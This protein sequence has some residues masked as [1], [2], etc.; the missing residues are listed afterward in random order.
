MTETTHRKGFIRRFFGAIGGAITWL[1]RVFTN[2]LFLLLLLFIFAAIFGKEERLTVPQGAA[3]KLAPTGFLVDERSPPRGLP[4]F[5]GGP[6]G[7]VETRVKD[8]VDAIDFAAK[9]KRISSIVLELDYLMGGGISKLEEVGA[10]LQR[11]KSADKPVYAVGDNFTQAQYFLASHA[12]EVYLNP[13]GSVLLTGF[14][15][16]RNYFKSALDKLKVNFHV[17]RVGDYKDF[18]EPYTRDD[19]SPASRENN[20]RW[21]HELWSE[22]TEQVTGLRNLPPQAIDIFIEELPQ[23]LR[24]HN[25]SWADAAL[26]NQLVDHLASRR[27]AVKA[28]QEKIGVGDDDQTYKAIDA[29]PYLR[30]QRLTHLAP[31]PGSR[32]VALISASGTIVD[33]EAPAGQ[34]G[35]VSLG[36]LIAQAREKEVAALVLRVDSGGGSAFASEAIRQELLATREANIPVVVSMGSV[37]ASGGY[38]IATGG[39]QIWA[40]PSTITGSIGVFGAFP[41]FEESLESIGIYNDGIGTSELAGTM[42]LDRALPEPAAEVLQLGVENTYDRFLRIV[43]E[44]R[45]STPDEVHKIAQGQVWTGRTAQQ[46]GLVDELGNLNDAI[47]GAAKLA[48]L[49]EYE[50]VEI[51]RELTP[52]ERFM[53]ALSDNIGA[54]VSAE[55][56]SNLPLGAWLSSLQPA[57]EP[58]AELQSYRD[59]RA[60]YARCLPCQAP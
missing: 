41:T 47:A 28:L 15:A 4:A 19:M 29:L 55:I 14:G 39:D 59:P 42:R 52:G 54:S 37:A 26:A 24:D 57:L 21:L 2:L 49:E 12:D 6:P 23:N 56:Q 50:L 53:R 44:A 25:G 45:G 11:F 30:N 22:Y 31:T 36:K 5:L 9:D 7:P 33:G 1:R 3:L 10:A 34:I 35:S 13:M 20:Q 17:F 40:T 51:K 58:L 32:K 27:V 38:W 43:A 48:E 46:L 8:L 18:I 60:I 16:Y